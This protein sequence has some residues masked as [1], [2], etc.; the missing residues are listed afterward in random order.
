M[1]HIYRI[2][3]TV[4]LES[5]IGYTTK[6]PPEGRWMQ[7]K[8]HAN[9]GKVQTRLYHDMR[10]FGN[11]KFVFD[12]LCW[13][14][15]IEDGAKIAEP[16]MIE[17]FSPTYNNTKGGRGCRERVLSADTKRKIGDANRGR[18][19]TPEFCEMDSKRMMG[20]PRTKESCEK[21]RM[22]MTGKKRGPYKRGEL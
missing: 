1:Y 16:L 13:G 15:D 12:V 20:V 11:E 6:N 3:N 8:G 18:K 14:E 21:Q 2:T 22:T 17:L 7:H 4:N 9:R 5:Y 19:R 10:K